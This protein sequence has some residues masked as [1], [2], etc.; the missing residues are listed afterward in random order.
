TGDSHMKASFMRMRREVL[1]AKGGGITISEIRKMCERI[2]KELSKE[3]SA[4]GAYDI[5]RGKGGLGEL[6]F[7]IQYLQM[8]HCRDHPELLV[9]NTLDAVRRI[10]RSGILEER[11]ARVL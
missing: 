1:L 7:I 6:E 2:S 5:K 8:K 9:Q 10:Y 3:S 11:D 4:T